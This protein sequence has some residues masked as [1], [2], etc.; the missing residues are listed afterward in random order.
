MVVLLLLL[1]SS[2]GTSSVGDG[3]GQ[4]QQAKNALLCQYLE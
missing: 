4:W 1:I 3:L 2:S